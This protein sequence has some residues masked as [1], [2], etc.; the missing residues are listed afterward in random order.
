MLRDEFLRSNMEARD[1]GSFEPGTMDL[2]LA[3]LGKAPRGT[4][5]H[6]IHLGE[7]LRRSDAVIEAAHNLEQDKPLIWGWPDWLNIISIECLKRFHEESFLHLQ[8]VQRMMKKVRQLLEKFSPFDI[9]D[10]GYIEFKDVQKQL[11]VAEL[12][13]DDWQMLDC[14]S[15]F[16][17]LCRMGYLVSFWETPGAFTPEQVKELEAHARLFYYLGEFFNVH[18]IVIGLSVLH[19][20]PN[21]SYP[22]NG[23][24]EKLTDLRL[25]AKFNLMLRILINLDIYEGM[26][27][28]RGY[29]KEL[30]SHEKVLP[31]MP[32]ELGEIGTGYLPLIQALRDQTSGAIIC[33]HN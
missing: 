25:N 7:N 19:H 32:R 24:V 5:E 27:G 4:D 26:T 28:V 18:R 1:F 12:T 21:K 22:H 23:I 20:H 17:D 16:H 14:A 8:R 30:W 3:V 15:W 13:D 9:P 11:S 6:I 2:V 31:L 33:P 10:Y 29:R